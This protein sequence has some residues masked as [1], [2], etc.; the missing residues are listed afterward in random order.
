MSRRHL[1]A[2]GAMVGMLRSVP[3]LAHDT[4][5][6]VANSP[7]GWDVS[8]MALLAAGGAMYLAGTL[9]LNR[10][11]KIV[12]APMRTWLWHHDS[13]NTSGRPDRW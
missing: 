7:S 4:N 13:K 5:H 3:A 1:I 8:V 10:R 11:G 6:V 12:H 2:I 9:E